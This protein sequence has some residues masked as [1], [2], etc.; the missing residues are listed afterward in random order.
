MLEV[1]NEGVNIITTSSF[2]SNGWESVLTPASEYRNPHLDAGAG[3]TYN[4]NILGII[5][6]AQS[7]F[8]SLRSLKKKTNGGF[9]SNQGMLLT[10]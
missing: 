5:S 9:I 2:F 10:H 1:I 7:F 3:W 8:S 4:I 6:S